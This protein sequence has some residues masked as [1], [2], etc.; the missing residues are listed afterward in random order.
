[1]WLHDEVSDEWENI[2]VLHNKR[3][4]YKQWSV[5]KKLLEGGEN[6]LGWELQ[7]WLPGCFNLNQDFI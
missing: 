3:F 4:H 5:K 2:S 6:S 7:K 1:M